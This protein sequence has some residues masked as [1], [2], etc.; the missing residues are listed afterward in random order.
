MKSEYDL[1]DEQK[2]AYADNEAELGNIETQMRS[3][4]DAANTRLA[5]AQLRF[6]PD[7]TYCL[8]C[9]CD[10]YV[11][12]NHTCGRRTCTHSRLSHNGFV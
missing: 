3:I 9:P 6:D 1:T 4:Q 11:G 5:A 10:E 7:G 2:K 12:P 8:Q